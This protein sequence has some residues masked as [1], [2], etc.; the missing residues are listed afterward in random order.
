MRQQ[1]RQMRSLFPLVF[2]GRDVLVDDRLGDVIEIAELRFPHH[3]S[4]LCDDRITVFESEHAGFGKRAIENFEAS[5][6]RIFRTKLR[7]WRPSFSRLRV[8]K[9]SVALA[10]GAATGILPA[11]TDTRTF[12]RQRA[13]GHRFGESPVE[14]RGA[15]AHLRAARKLA[16]HL[17]IQVE[18]FGHDGN[19]SRDASDHLNIDSGFDYV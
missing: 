17:R 16:H 9:N 14:W 18:A 19:L 11:Q 6:R 8:V 1:E 15:F 4:I 7:E 13:E 5:V 2:A 10:E 3:Q 12:E